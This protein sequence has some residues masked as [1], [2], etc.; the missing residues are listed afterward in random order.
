[1]ADFLAELDTLADNLAKSAETLRGLRGEAALAR[2]P[3]P[4]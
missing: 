2:A 3:S 4:A 1:M